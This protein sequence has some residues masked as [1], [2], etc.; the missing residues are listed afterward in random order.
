MDF[1]L[2]GRDDKNL[3]TVHIIALSSKFSSD[4][5]CQLLDF[6]LIAENRKLP[7]LLAHTAWGIDGSLQDLV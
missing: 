5:F 4:E 2:V 6:F 1:L 7:G 3:W